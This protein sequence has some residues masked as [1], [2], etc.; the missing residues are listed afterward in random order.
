MTSEAISAR[1]YD[2]WEKEGRPDG[3]DL[4]HWL[5]AERMMTQQQATP[6]ATAPRRD[7]RSKG[8]R[9]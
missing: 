6:A 9:R 7:D 4:A 3:Q 2:L 1:A 8:R 5:E